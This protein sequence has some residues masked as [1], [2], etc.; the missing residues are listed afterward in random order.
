MRSCA[1][2]SVRLA[3]VL[4]ARALETGRTICHTLPQW[5]L[6]Q[7]VLPHWGLVW[8]NLHST[9]PAR[10]QRSVRHGWPPDDLQVYSHVAQDDASSLV[11]RMVSCIEQVKTWMTSN[12]LRLNPSKTELIWLGLSRR[13]HHFPADKVKICRHPACRVFQRPRRPNWWCDDADHTRQPPRRRLLLPSPADQDH[14]SFPFHRCSPLIGSRFYSRAC[15]LLQRSAGLVP[16]IPD[17]QTS[18]GSARCS[19]TRT[20]T[21]VS[22]FRHQP[23]AP[24]VTLAWHSQSGEVQ[25]RPSCLQVPPRVGSPVPLRLLR[26]GAS[27]VHSL[28][29]AFSPVPGASSHR[30]ANEN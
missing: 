18:I 17:R 2:A 10:P 19:E 7:W 6:P 25:D 23:H 20:S 9:W 4:G 28:L 8:H 21:A 16:E 14:P 29:P 3:P 12:R 11:V 5:I 30:P 1:L 27:I 13:L 15:R 26:P 22:V 24:A